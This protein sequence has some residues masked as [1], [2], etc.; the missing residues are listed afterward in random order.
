MLAVSRDFAASP[1]NLL[2]LLF[3]KS[4]NLKVSSRA[5]FATELV[6]MEGGGVLVLPHLKMRSQLIVGNVFSSPPKR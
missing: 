2:P 4:I 6:D 3:G 5:D 1:A